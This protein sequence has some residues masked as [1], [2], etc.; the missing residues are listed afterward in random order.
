VDLDI[1]WDLI[2]SQPHIHVFSFPS[3]IYERYITDESSYKLIYNYI[4]S[5]FLFGRCAS[6]KI[7]KT[8]KYFGPMRIRQLEIKL[9]DNW[10]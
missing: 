5:H 7:F 1:I 6:D 2:K 8:K 9:V 4:L 3:L 10:R